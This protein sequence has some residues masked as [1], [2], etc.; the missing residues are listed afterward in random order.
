M[1]MKP[2][3]IKFNRRPF[4][5]ARDEA[6]VPHVEAADWRTAVYAL[7]YLHALDRTT[8]LLFARVV[9]G[10]RSAEVIAD[11]PELVEMDRFFRQAGLFVRLDEEAGQL[12][13]AER[14]ELTAYCEGVN[15]G[16]R[17]A[18]RS[19]PMRAVGYR[20]EPWDVQAVMLIANLLNYN[21]LAIG[22]QH[23]ERVILE[24]IHAGAD[25]ERLRELFSPLLDDVDFD[26]LR[27]VKISR[28]LSDEA[29]EMIADLPMLAGSNAWAVRPER[30]ASGS[31]LLASDPHL[32]INR[33]PAIWYEAVLRFG[34]EYVIGATLPGTPIFAVGR[35]RHLAWGVT[36]HKS[37][38]CDYFIEDC[39]LQGG[40]GEGA[41]GRWQFRRGDEWRDF[42]VRQETI[43]RKGGAT[44]EQRVYFNE[45]GTL[46]GDPAALGEGL[47]LLNAWTGDRAGVGRSL[48]TWSQLVH[49]RGAQAAMDL[50]REC[51]HP[52][53]AWVFA[54]RAGHIGLQTSGWAPLRPP[55]CSG[56]TPMPA[57]D[58]RNH[59]LGIRP[60]EDLPRVLDPSEGF[61]STANETINPP[62]GPPLVTLP[63][64]E[65]R[66]RRIDDV[67]R[68]TSRA[69][70]ADMQDLQYDVVSLQ[71]LD[72][73]AALLPHLPDGPLK[74]R[75]A[76]WDGNYAEDSVEATLFQDLYR[77]V[78]VEIFGQP[79][80][81]HGGLGWRRVAFL[82]TRAGFS[83][84]IVA[85]IDRLLQRDESTWWQARGKGE[86]VRKAAAAVEVDTARPWGQVNTFRL[87]NR[88]FENA[89]F[90]EVLRFHSRPLAMPGNFAT[91]FQGNLFRLAG[92]ETSFAPSIHFVCDLGTDE[93]WT[94]LPGG[95]SE[96]RFSRWYKSDVPR[97]QQGEYKRLAGDGSA[98]GSN[99]LHLAEQKS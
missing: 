92:R 95:P 52:T 58:E 10:G 64:M 94:N 71:A 61:I 73:L 48:G 65:F 75:L 63:M 22:Q 54:D 32:E 85:C 83:Y 31:A 17:Q 56:V 78:V 82:S 12:P 55:H 3:R 30:S 36:H 59:W 14:A 60:T 62:N 15:D 57:W 8:Q 86:L 41:H 18:G 49:E 21:G 7:G 9:G 70:I 88:F 46:D 40:D 33:L 79:P 67:L 96:S 98:E 76:A 26:L 66:K 20:A 69:E 13:E 45:L 19:L 4:T 44:V 99:Q 28:R 38:I 97:W 90:G 5:A 16:L 25:Q 42:Q 35:N 11:R 24:L 74:Q 93:A 50:V 77:R 1:A 68:R 84:L 72:L 51:P 23:Q 53:L 81:E 91:P 87:L 37:D 29:L 43:R 47:Q 2:L 39:R 89:F 6:G 80:G 27:R 34:G